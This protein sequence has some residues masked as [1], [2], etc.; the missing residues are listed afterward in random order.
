MLGVRFKIVRVETFDEILPKMKAGQIDLATSIRAM[1][2][3]AEYLLFQ[4]P[5]AT[6][7][8]GIVVRESVVGELSLETM[9]GMKV[10]MVQGYGNTG[11]VL[12]RHKDVHVVLVPDDA[13]GLRKVSFGEVDAAIVDIAVASYYIEKLG[14]TN[15]RLAGR[16]GQSFDLRFAS[17]KDWPVLASILAKAMARITYEQRAHIYGKWVRLGLVES[18]PFYL[19]MVFWVVILST[20]GLAGLAMAVAMTWNRMLR[21]RVHRQTER[22]RLEFERSERAHKAVRDSD[23]RFRATFEHA[24][25]GLVHSRPDGSFLSMNQ[26]FCDMLGYSRREMLELNVD[27]ITHPDD[28]A[29]A[30]YNTERLWA[31]DTGPFSMEKRYIH[32]DKSIVWGSATVSLMCDEDGVPQYSIAAILDITGRKNA[33][34]D[35]QSIFNEMLDGFSLHDI[36]CDDSG[37][38]VDYRFLAV[39]P[40]FERLTGLK[41]ADLVGRRVLEVMPQTEAHWIDTFG[42][43]AITGQPAY[44]EN[45]SGELGR[46]YEVTAYRPAEGQFACI[47]VDVTERKRAESEREILEKQVRH[48]QKLESLGVLAGGIA[49]DFNNLL[50]VILGNAELASMELSPGSPAD[51]SIDEIKKASQRAAELCTQML[52]YSGRGQF[53]IEPINLSRIVSDMSNMLEVTISKKAMLRTEFAADLPAVDADVTQIRQI[54]M[55]LI[56]N[57]SEAIGDDHGVIHITTDTIECDHEYLKST[58]LGEDLPEGLYVRLEVADTGCGMD[59]ETQAKLF[60]PFFTTKFTGRGLGL[61]A[62]L[63]IIRGHRGAVTV[64]SRLGKGTTFNVLLPA[65]SNEVRETRQVAEAGGDG[66]VV[67]GTVLLADDESSVLSIARRLLER[68]GFS[69]ICAVDGQEAV[70]IYR[71]RHDEIDCVI[72]DLAMPRMDGQEAYCELQRIRPDVRVIISSG[73][74]HQDIEDRFT[75]EGLAGFIQKPYEFK[76]L[77][78]TIKQVLSGG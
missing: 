78:D 22:L 75:G 52:A 31:G 28:V 73:Y 61:A 10:A 3:R 25:V 51:N 74:G 45:Y 36:I 37:K 67:T 50:M 33:E 35:Y 53:L 49:H 21:R 4:A 44:F 62:V 58:Y 64:S 56:T 24:A 5:H 59:A 42:Q 20:S 48:A 32:K 27:E 72:L 9:G 38:P 18:E 60:D 11:N 57:A 34:R 7:T 66:E 65:C 23:R 63:G 71:D 16:T 69:V 1:P 26:R 40:A 17:R 43:V 39:N 19:S 30:C 47:F 8:K 15:L 76:A 6:V 55:N 13:A 2:A 12:E 46:H 29:E 77:S 14:L 68:I 54:I 41:A 70:D